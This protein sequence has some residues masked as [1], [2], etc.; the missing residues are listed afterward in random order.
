MCRATHLGEGIFKIR[1]L[2]VGLTPCLTL[3]SFYL[4]QHFFLSLV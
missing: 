3:V 4:T 2:G 1:G